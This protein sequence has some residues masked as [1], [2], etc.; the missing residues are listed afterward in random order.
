MSNIVQKENSVLREIAKEVP[1]EEITSPK[2]QKI[3]SDMKQALESQSDGVALA[4]PQIG[5]PLRIFIVSKKAFAIMDDEDPKDTSYEDLICINP[6][7]IKK[8]KKTQIMD[9]GCLSVRGSYGNVKRA[10]QATIEA[11]NEHADKFTRGGGGLLAQIFQ[12]EIDH[13][14]GILFIDKAE[15]VETIPIEK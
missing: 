6:Q 11:Y 3:I 1:R 10:R 2:I 9:E 8:S 14:N 7:I 12:H 5:I 13:L 4:A 15:D